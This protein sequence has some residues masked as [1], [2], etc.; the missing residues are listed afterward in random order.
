MKFP[1]LQLIKWTK[2]TLCLMVVTSIF[3]YSP[4][5]NRIFC[6]RTV[7]MLHDLS[8]HGLLM[9]H[10]LIDE[11]YARPWSL[12]VTCNEFTDKS[13]NRDFCEINNRIAVHF[14]LYHYLIFSVKLTESQVVFLTG[15]GIK[16]TMVKFLT[17]TYTQ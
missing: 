12:G 4:I 14:W 6:K 9:F 1:I 17:P 7:K 13:L 16:D 5:I 2:S 15:S 3:Y 10:K 8:L 11:E